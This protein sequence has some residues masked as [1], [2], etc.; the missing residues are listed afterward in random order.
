MLLTSS[1]GGTGQQLAMQHNGL[2]CLLKTPIL[3]VP[4]PVRQNELGSWERLAVGGWES[5]FSTS[6]P[7]NA[8]S[9]WPGS[10]LQTCTYQGHGLRRQLE[11]TWLDRGRSCVALD[12]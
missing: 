4:Y 12:E 6:C 9:S 10:R 5:V 1:G 3:A 8:G 2:R 7:G 11:P